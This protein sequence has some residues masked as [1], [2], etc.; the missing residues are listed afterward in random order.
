MKIIKRQIAITNTSNEPVLTSDTPVSQVSTITSSTEE[1]PE[2]TVNPK[3]PIQSTSRTQNGISSVQQTTRQTD[4]LQ[5]SITAAKTSEAPTETNSLNAAS[6]Q[7]LATT[8]ITTIEQ[9]NNLSP[10]KANN[11]QSLLMG[12]IIGGVCLLVAVAALVCFKRFSKPSDKQK[13]RLQPSTGG[14]RKGSHTKIID[15]KSSVGNNDSIHDSANFVYPN[16]QNHY[17]QNVNSNYPSAPYVYDPNYQY[18]ASQNY[19]IVTPQYQHD[20]HQPQYYNNVPFNNG[21]L[22]QD[23]VYSENLTDSSKQNLQNND[24]VNSNGPISKPSTNLDTNFT[25]YQGNIYDRN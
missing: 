3:P 9:K 13:R 21:G 25:S 14:D 18:D 24:V 12:S 5:S 11:S 1:P 22:P 16:D 20:Y 4:G 6:L 8:T 2:T 10:A 19:N 17:S 7:P 23:Y 15:D